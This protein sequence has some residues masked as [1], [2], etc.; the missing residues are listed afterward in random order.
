MIKHIV[1]WQLKDSA[2]GRS[3]AENAE[4]MK[5][6]ILDLKNKIPQ[7]IKIEAGINILP[8]S[9]SFDVVLNSDFANQADLDIYQVHPDHVKY[10]EFIKD[11]VSNKRFIDYEV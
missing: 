5:K 8:A 11:L 9:D 7:L 10:K 4:R 2:D 3:K 6:E 1:L